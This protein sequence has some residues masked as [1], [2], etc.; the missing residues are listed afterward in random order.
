MSSR[1]HLDVARPDAGSMDTGSPNTARR[2]A[3]DPA[4]RRW[5]GALAGAVGV[6]VGLVPH[7]LHHVGLIAGTAVISGVGGSVLFGAVGLIATVPML[8]RLRRRFGTWWAPGLALAIFAVMF[9][10]S[11]AVV[12]P[13]LRGAATDPADGHDGDRPM[14]TSS[15]HDGHHR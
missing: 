9:T 8:V 14:P 13:A 2:D 4:Q 3:S 15:G 6:G 7:L 1:H 11:T 5:W 10:L 12:G